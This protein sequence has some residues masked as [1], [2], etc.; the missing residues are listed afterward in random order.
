[1]LLAATNI[2][3]QG[4]R[5][6]K[7]ETKKGNTQTYYLRCYESGTTILTNA[8]NPTEDSITLDTEWRTKMTYKGRSGP[9]TST[10]T[11]TY[12]D[13]YLENIQIDEE[14]DLMNVFIYYNMKG[15]VAFVI[16]GYP[17]YLNIPMD[18]FEKMEADLKKGK[19]NLEYKESVDHSKYFRI[20]YSLNL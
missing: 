5:M 12:L 7:V 2:F 16:F 1:M 4:S 18:I 13:P 10:V 11:E 3:S 15:E 9:D 19:L 14:D 20:V 17:S 6:I 8:N